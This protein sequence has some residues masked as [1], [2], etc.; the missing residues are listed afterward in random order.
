MKGAPMN[1]LDFSF[2]NV[3]HSKPIKSFVRRQ[4]YH[5]LIKHGNEVGEP[6]EGKIIL[7][8]DPFDNGVQCEIEFKTTLGYWRSV[9]FNKGVN[10][11]VTQGLKGLTRV[12]IFQPLSKAV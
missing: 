9:T 6:I 5:W 1:N 12:M 2:L 3:P 10:S 7:E 11:A 8:R 4:V